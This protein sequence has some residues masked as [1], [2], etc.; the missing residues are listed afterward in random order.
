MDRKEARREGPSRR[1]LMAGI[2]ASAVALSAGAALSER[3]AI[4]TGFVF[5]D[6]RGSGVRRRGDSGIPGVLVSNG[7][8]VVK[9]EADGSWR[10][11]VANG[12]SLFVIKPPGWTTPTGKGGIPQFSYLHQPDGT[13]D[14]LGLHH[15]GVAPTG[16]LP[17]TVDF[18]LRR[19]EER[20]EFEVLLFADTQPADATELDYLR[21][22]IIAGVI[23]SEAAFGINHGDVVFDDLSLYG[24]YL[25]ILETTGVPWHHCPGNHDINSDARDDRHS[26][27]TWKRIFGPRHYAFQYG[28]ATF[29]LLDNVYYHGY[30]PGAPLSGEYWGLIGARQLQFVRNVLANVPPESLIVVSMHIPLRT[31]QQPTGPADT[32]VDRRA[33]LALLSRCPHTVSFSGHMHTTEHHYLHHDEGFTGPS[34][35]HHHVLTT[36]SGGWWSGPPTRRGI[37]FADSPDGNPNGFHILAIDGNRYTTR[38]VPAAEKR[39]GQL[40]VLVAGPQRPADRGR[41]EERPHTLCGSPVPAAAVGSYEL[42][43]NVFDGG[44]KTKV[45]YELA[46]CGERIW[47]QRTNMCDPFIVDVY[48][49]Y[50][51]TLKSWMEPVPCSHIWKA[52]LPAGLKAGAHR[53]IV[54]AWDEYGREHCARLVLEVAA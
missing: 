28:R 15:K 47:M 10:L 50:A 45:A 21:E 23:G 54:R 30:N 26:R 9:T 1:E 42:I 39:T 33:L 49:R 20:S 40:R 4:A 41:R 16:A 2:G 11:P 27:E 6:R 43:A 18:A 52:R 37:P 22:D 31:Y 13:P 8:D 3:Q 19:Q 5:E 48:A 35:H 53:L 44:P 34:P 51:D 25:R 24:R 17:A 29:I 12:D 14:H 36:A 32:T 38:F 7:R 46:N